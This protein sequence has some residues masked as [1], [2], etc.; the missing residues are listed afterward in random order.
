MGAATSMPLSDAM[1]W[2]P[3]RGARVN[4]LFTGTPW[5]RWQVLQVTPVLP[6]CAPQLVLM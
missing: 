2:L 1:P 5:P 3:A 4:Q 6:T